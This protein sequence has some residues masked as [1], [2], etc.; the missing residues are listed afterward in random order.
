MDEL[1]IP[2]CVTGV[3]N[4][5]LLDLSENFISEFPTVSLKTFVSLKFLNLS[6]NLIQVSES[7]KYSV[8]ETVYSLI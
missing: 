5:E 1:W 3:E 4:L 6:S 7:A 8:P 2:C